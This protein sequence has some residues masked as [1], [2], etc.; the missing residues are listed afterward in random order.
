M[1]MA[2]EGADGLSQVREGM[3]VVDRVGGRLGTVE[4]VAMGD[5]EA[6]TTQGQ[7]AARPDQVYQQLLQAVFGREPRIPEQFHE[8]LVR[9]GF[10]KI[11]SKGLLDRD[12]YATRQP[13]RCRRGG[14]GS[15][16][17]YRGPKPLD[18]LT[19]AVQPQTQA[20]GTASKP[21]TNAT[22]NSPQS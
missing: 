14:D 18:Q 16:D 17:R 4:L 7:E 13:G 15:S 1:T 11:D 10:V 21:P 19:Q 6:V 12:A 8:Q 3:Q 9:E 20:S 22:A 5:P 2:N